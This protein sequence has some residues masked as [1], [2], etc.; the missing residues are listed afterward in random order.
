MKKVLVI[1]DDLNVRSIILDILEAEDFLG[2]GAENGEI[3][4]KLAKEILPD[5]IICDVMMPGLD[6][7]EVL[8][9]LIYGTV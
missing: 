9:E 1:E 3:G 6:G 5:L 8:E 7:H 4:V 2:I